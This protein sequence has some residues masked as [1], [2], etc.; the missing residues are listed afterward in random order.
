MFGA[1]T[2]SE[3]PDENADPHCLMRADVAGHFIKS[4][5]ID[6]ESR[7]SSDCAASLIDQYPYCSYICE[8]TFVK[9]LLK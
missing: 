7:S 6:S 5:G 3:V 1:S 2:K 9:P 4:L 8:E